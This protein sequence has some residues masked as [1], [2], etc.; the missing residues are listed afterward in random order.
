MRAKVV[1]IATEE[2][3][4]QGLSDPGGEEVTALVPG[5]TN[6]LQHYPA[7]SSM[8]GVT[9]D[10]QPNVSKVSSQERTQMRT[11]KLLQLLE[12]EEMDLPGDDK[13]KLYTLLAEQHEA[14]VLEEKERGE[15]DLIQFQI[16]TDNAP[17]KK[18][19][20]RRTPF[21]VR[22]EVARQ[23]KD[24][25]ETGVIQPSNSPW[26]SPI[27]L[28]RKKDGSLRF[29]IDYR[30]LN[31]VTKVDTY[32]LPRI[33]DLLD[34]LGKS[35]YF[36]TL[37]L[38]SGYWQIPVHP[39]SQE[40][41]AFVTTRGLFEFRVMPFGLR[42][43]PAVFQRLMERVLTGLNP[44]DGPDFVDA[45]IDDVLVFS[46]TL[47][48]HL[49]HLSLVLDAIKKASLKLK[50]P[51]CKFF[52][53][54]VEFLGH[55]ITA[56]GLKP[57]PAHTA[58][59]TNFPEPRDIK[60]IRQFVGL[61]SYYRRF[62]SNF[63]K[64]A[65]PLHALTRKGAP[66]HWTKECQEAFTSLK[67]KLSS[68]PVLSYPDF[69]KDFVLETDAS[70][71]GLG[72]VLSQKQSDGKL[73]PIAFASRAL[74]P[75]EKNYAVT[76]LETLAV[77]WACSHFHA[78]LYGHN[79]TVYTDH[80]AVKAI[81]ETPSPS[82]KHARWWSKVYGSG[83]KSLHIVY[84]AGRDNANADALSRNPQLPPPTE[85]MADTDVQVAVVTTSNIHDVMSPRF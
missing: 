4:T 83:V 20:L 1:S 23:L 67:N 3:Q 7:S 80:S 57:N 74:S 33:D 39:D 26:T 29:C 78:Y 25:Q 81:L 63:A 68:A 76:E 77:V 6:S 40:K 43:A 2:T 49:H 79:V 70:I 41:T 30:H 61:A 50:L 59:V 71:R 19:L 66:F 60:G 28:V 11:E 58:A 65:H 5:S 16:D 82:G 32:P 46:Q 10:L 62:I 72:A 85:E 53:K 84:R 64:I 38:A 45:Y 17:P 48:E 73:H 52:R 22:Q 14:F 31:S 69:C 27:V 8:E 44:E 36:S 18:Q 56:E 24:M 47:D 55:V 51:K 42:N 13:E 15:T 34:Q 75:P 21:A 9:T 35:K 37:D 12:Q 54:E